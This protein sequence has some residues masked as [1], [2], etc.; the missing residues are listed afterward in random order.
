MASH[1]R[2]LKQGACA[3]KMSSKVVKASLWS[4]T[5][6]FPRFNTVKSLS[7]PRESTLVTAG[8]VSMHASPSP[9]IMGPRL[10]SS[11]TGFSQGFAV[12]WFR[13][14]IPDT[15]APDHVTQNEYLGPGTRQGPRLNFV[16]TFLGGECC[17]ATQ[18]LFWKGRKLLVRDPV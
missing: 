6:S 18:T 2:A 14:L 12:N 7:P 11:C 15:F 17:A 13:W 9:Q 5:T 10:P 4:R 16:N 1:E 8:H 3:I